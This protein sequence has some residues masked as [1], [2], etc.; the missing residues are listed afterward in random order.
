VNLKL[1]ADSFSGVLGSVARGIRSGTGSPTYER[2]EVG[3]HIGESGNR[4]GC[5]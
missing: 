1:A 4:A 2:E 3:G 5:S